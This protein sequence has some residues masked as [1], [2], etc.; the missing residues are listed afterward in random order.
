MKTVARIAILLILIV[1]RYRS[2]H[3][4]SVSGV[5]NSYYHITAVNTATN[6]V[7]VDNVSGLFVGQPVLVIQMKGA[8]IAAT[9]DANYGNITSINSA[10]NYEFNIIC[11]ITGNDVWLKNKL[12]NAYDPNGQVQLVSYP[13]YPSMTIAGAVTGQAWDP[14]TGKGGVVVLSATGTITLNA[15]VDV[16]GQGFQGGA[17]VNYAIPPYNCDWITTVSDYYY[18]L[19]AS[20]YY[21]GGKKG[22]GVAAYILNE[23]YGRGK[24]AS[25]GGGGDNGNSGGAGGGNYGAGGAG[26]QRTGESFFDCHAQYPGIGGSSLAA[27]GYSTG[28][29]RIFLGG[30]GGSGQENNGVSTPGANGGGIIILSAQTIVGGGGRLLANGLQP[31]NPTNTDPLQA[32]G[33]GGGGGGAGGTI[34]LN[35]ATIS[36][37]ITAQA[38]GGRG[39]DASNLVNDCT[40]PGGGGGGGMVWAAGASFP[41]AVTATV[42]GGANGV[43]SSGN[44]KVSCRGLSNGATS[45]AAGLN[46]SGYTP[47]VSTGPVCTVLASPAL[48][49]FT[50]T[51]SDPGVVLAWAL[52][53]PTTISNI[54]SFI[55][56][57][58]T[59]QSNFSTQATLASAVDSINY[60][61]TDPA[62]GIEG[63]VSYRLAW[64][65]EHGEWSY[66]RIL[67]VDVTPGPDGAS[68]RLQPSPATDQ[69][70]MTVFS[71]TAGDAGIMISNVL[72]QSLISLRVSLRKG[73]NTVGIPL[74]NLA[75]ATYFLVLESG[76]RRRAKAF[77]KR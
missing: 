59:D 42:N 27:Y 50:A 29:N 35:A 51:R 77:I 4:Q 40:G 55:V 21:T 16:S 72:G 34:I 33:D 69:L 73:M 36:G 49:Y 10:G 46:Q 47:P 48:I 3:G 17:L 70:T 8:A 53:V 24:L 14:V 38:I 12:V 56:Q 7:T 26:G 1:F 43:V 58:S 71:W 31:R 44:T 66:S 37:A 23:E 9:N 39:S 5:L 45:G 32:E 52:S 6:S 30:G 22:E 60:R 63:P 54:R 62:G 64:Q 18:N 25:G 11:S 28:A 68:I 41:A 15:D 65:N 57:R 2:A 67:T 74:G 61:Y 13:S 20:G 75:P 19:P 76:G